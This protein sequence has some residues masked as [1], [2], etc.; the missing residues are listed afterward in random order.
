[1]RTKLPLV[2]K[3][4][5]FVCRVFS[6]LSSEVAVSF[7]P[8]C[9]CLVAC[10]PT[11]QMQCCRGKD[12]CGVHKALFRTLF[13]DRSG[14]GAQV[15]TAEGFGGQGGWCKESR[16]IQEI[17]ATVVPLLPMPPHKKGEHNF[18]GTIFSTLALSVAD[19][20]PKVLTKLWLLGSLEVFFQYKG[21][22]T[23]QNTKASWP[24]RHYPQVVPKRH[25]LLGPL[26][27]HLA[28]NATYLLTGSVLNN[29]EL[30]VR[31]TSHVYGTKGA[32]HTIRWST[33]C[34][35]SYMSRGRHL[36]PKFMPISFLGR[37]SCF[38]GV[39]GHLA[40][41]KENPSVSWNAALSCPSNH[42]NWYLVLISFRSRSGA[43]HS[44]DFSGW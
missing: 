8:T 19:R 38:W 28:C 17:R 5:L 32:K 12:D 27:S 33:L 40:L 41:N 31:P 2:K 22:C 14:C 29:A 18:C 35:I 21:C 6:P 44:L 11:H 15:R 26:Q 34:V 23:F 24:R 9:L 7:H 43:D 16:P 25:R 37:V 10:S 3:G 39:S 4:D 42:A 36:L 13:R 30:R 1:M 20:L